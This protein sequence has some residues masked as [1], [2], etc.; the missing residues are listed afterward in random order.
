MT[1]ITRARGSII[2]DV[3]Y[4]FYLDARV[5]RPDKGRFIL[6]NANDDDRQSEARIK[7]NFNTTRHYCQS[8]RLLSRTADTRCGNTVAINRKYI[9]TVT[10]STIFTTFTAARA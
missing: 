10:K 2:R 7:Y 4:N 9:V 8:K 6:P 5:E 1:R 3:E